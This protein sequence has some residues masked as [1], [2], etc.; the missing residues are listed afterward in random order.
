MACTDIVADRWMDDVITPALADG[1]LG[2]PFEALARMA[3]A[4]WKEK[5]VCDECVESMKVEWGEIASK[6]WEKVGGWVE[7]AEK[8]SC[9]N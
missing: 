5:G 1:E 9:R 3:A 4:P 6:L 7:E 2:R 8:Q